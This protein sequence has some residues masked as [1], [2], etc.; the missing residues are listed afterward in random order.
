MFLGRLQADKIGRVD[1]P[2]VIILAGPNGAGKTTA[3]R[4]LLQ[5]ALAVDEFVNA[6]TIA[7]GLS[8]FRPEEVAL[9]AGRVMLSRLDALAGMRMDFAFET[10]LASRSFAPWLRQ[11]RRSG[12]EFHLLYL[13]LR[14]P[15]LAVAR[16]ASR[17][18]LGGH[19]VPADT[20]RRRY[21]RGLENFF[22]LYR[23]VAT[24]WTV[25]DNTLG[26]QSVVASGYRD[27]TAQVFEPDIWLKIKEEAGP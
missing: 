2:H 25:Y 6:D 10:T 4:D 26:E 20:I 16:V 3:A 18:R 21:R 9:E 13:W 23:P 8:A 17:V 19:G 15:E 12:Y 27:D 5:G 24:T 7:H 1:S 22:S 11:L 14:D